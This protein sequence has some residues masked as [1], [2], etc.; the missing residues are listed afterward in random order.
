[1]ASLK[2]VFVCIILFLR[3]NDTNE[4][5]LCAPKIQNC[6]NVVLFSNQSNS[7]QPGRYL[8]GLNRS[9]CGKRVSNLNLVFSIYLIIVSIVAFLGN[10]F[11]CIVIG[12]SIKLRS[13]SVNHL[14][15]S[16][17]VSDIL[18]SVLS[19]P[20]KIHMG[21]HNQ[22]FCMS[23][24]VCW[25]FFYSDIFANCSSVTH[26]LVINIQRFVAITYPFDSQFIL[27]RQRV[28][29]LIVL[30]WIYSAVWS[31]L[32]T[33]NWNDPSMRGVRML[34]TSSMKTCS[35]NNPIYWTCVFVAVFL[36]PLIIMGCLQFSILQSVKTH[37][38]HMLK[39]EP[40]ADR[41]VRLRKREIRVTKTVSI[42]YAAF[43]TCWLPVCLITVSSSW[44]PVCFQRFRNWN[45]ELFVATFLIFVH[46]LP[47]L[48]STLNPF[49]YVISGDEFKAALK[50]VLLKR[51]RQTSRLPMTLATDHGSSWV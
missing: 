27:S 33:F 51:K 9:P 1:M 30:V 29:L 45:Q 32:C 22:Q 26:L 18:V 37:T 25:F 8:D 6:S 5:E 3:P 12:R 40:N 20:I 23:P 14:L 47:P 17:A 31:L 48:S 7:T 41:I 2:L 38:R 21:F 15:L 4:K 10:V 11:V 39:V 19:L 13:Q 28:D 43:T 44:C 46:M 49:I 34:E 24:R 50:T 42:V 16:L 35:N 36:I